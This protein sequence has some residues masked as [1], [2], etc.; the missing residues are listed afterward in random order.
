MKKIITFITLCFV[1][2]CC[3]VPASGATDGVTHM[4]IKN[5]GVLEGLSNQYIMDITE[6]NRGFLWVATDAGLYRFDG[7]VFLPFTTRNT[8]FI[9]NSINCLFYEEEND[10]LWIGTKLGL[11]KMNC[12]TL[13]PEKIKEELIPEK[14]QIYNVVS[15]KRS[16][17]GQ[18]LWI[19][20]RHVDIINYDIAT[21]K[22]KIYN[23]YNVPGLGDTFND[24]LED[25]LG[26]LLVANSGGGMSRIHL[27]SGRLDNFTH[28]SD[29]PDGIPGNFVECLHR[30][31]RGNIWIGTN[32]GLAIYD[33]ITQKFKTFHHDENNSES[34]V[35]SHVYDMCETDDGQLWIGC[36]I[37]GVSILNLNDSAMASPD[38]IRFSNFATGITDDGSGLASSYVRNVY[39]D[40]HGNMWVGHYGHGLDFISHQKRIF[41]TLPLTERTPDGIKDCTASSLMALPDGDVIGGCIGELVWIHDKKIVR[42]SPI[43]SPSPVTAM[44]DKG[45]GKV[46]LG[47]YEDGLREYDLATGRSV[48]IPMPGRRMTVLIICPDGNGDYLIGTDQG[49]C[50]LKDGKVTQMED[51]PNPVMH[52]SI[53]AIT[54]DK[55]GRIWVG[56]YGTGVFIFDRAFNFIKYLTSAGDIISNA[57]K[58]IYCDSRGWMWIAGQDGLSC[59]TQPNDFSEIKNYTYDNGLED[60]HIRAISE[61]LWGNVWFST[62]NGLGRWNKRTSKI[63]NYDYHQG[64]P[65]NSFVDHSVAMS[66]NGEMYF[67]S[68][69][70]LCVFDPR[71]V[72]VN[73]P[74][75]PVKITEISVPGK[76]DERVDILPV[77][78]GQVKLDYDRNSFTVHFTVDDFAQS[79]LV[80]YAYQMIGLGD[81]W[82]NVRNDNEVSFR[83]LQPGKYVFNV[84]ARLSNQNWEESSVSSVTIV[85]TPPLWLTWWAKLLY[86]LLAATAIILAVRIYNRRVRFES[87]LELERRKTASELELNNERLRFFTNITHE[88]RT[89]LTLILGP[90][91]DLVADDTLDTGHKTRVKLIHKSSM[92]LLNLINQ[93]L[94]FRKAET[95]N[96]NL[97][98]TKGRLDT[99]VTEIGLRF[100][101]LNRNAGVKFVI[102]CDHSIGELY[103]DPEVISIVINNLLSNALKYTPDGTITLSLSRESGKEGDSAVISV[104]DTGYGI[105]A[106]ALPHIFDRYYQAKGKH[107]A[108]GTGIGLALVKSL[109]ML[110]HG[111]IEVESEENKGATF[112]FAIPMDDTYPQAQHKEADSMD[113]T[114][115]E[116]MATGEMEAESEAGDNRPSI[117]IV[118]DND[119]IRNYVEETLGEKYRVY[120]AV[121]GKEGL[122]Q[123]RTHQ[124]DVIVSDIMMPVMDGIELC[125]T[126]KQSIATSHIPVILLTAK[127]SLSDKEEGYQS[128]ADSY[129]TKPF[130]AK[131]LESRIAN[132]MESRRRMAS[133]FA[134]LAGNEAASASPAPTTATAVDGKDQDKP[135]GQEIRLSQLDEQ[136]MLKFNKLIEENIDNENLDM[137]FIQDKM[138]MSHSTFYRKIKSL[139]GM[140]GIEY[141][142]KLRLNHAARLIREGAGISEAA[143]RSGFNDLVYFRKCFKNEFGVAPS[144]Y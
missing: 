77:P 87:T 30:D 101:E 6:D 54:P 136:F 70:S 62:N 117:L 9:S 61:D 144:K 97:C 109:T 42:R 119:D 82:I 99:L 143:F 41:Y 73:L 126:L 46:L 133:F 68:L 60:V 19:T 45:E 57:I 64:V 118:E 102:E 129:L 36:D 37:G 128:G 91:E 135:T 5:Y 65:R 4:S 76:V 127:D 43:P 31:R 92:R 21:G 53:N 141:L 29:N 116:G 114:E 80:E 113:G 85:I 1:A 120:G 12:A 67:S 26:N 35:G 105:S 90:L 7:K 22:L 40:R 38:T 14:P 104:T 58:D 96:R 110:H 25:G 2:L 81:E 78:D 79:H 123:A 132:L 13:V 74:P 39:R 111:T 134:S 69:N 72:D 52:L 125:H 27:E 98:V 34:L 138:H 49:L 131:L 55:E 50:R 88:L 63:E 8:S 142:R 94:E 100:K 24:V 75:V 139:T 47:L 83:Y 115:E 17:D 20:N 3:H 121:N 56:T 86:F 140:S 16:S 18:S 23:A 108:S 66:T 33:P 44:Y 48:D 10:L 95:Q 93:I 71:D 103:Y 137:S 11:F 89:P 124:P 122:E 112:R 106:E 32:K 15:I 130:S 59:V 84:R 107:Q 51:L 28:S